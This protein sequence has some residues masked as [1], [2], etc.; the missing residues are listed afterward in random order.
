MNDEPVYGADEQKSKAAEAAN[1]R[2]GKSI[3]IERVEEVLALGA[4][5]VGLSCPHCLT[6]FEDGRLRSEQ[7]EIP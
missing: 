5:T 4:R 2:H 6:M 3:N 7:P 1:S